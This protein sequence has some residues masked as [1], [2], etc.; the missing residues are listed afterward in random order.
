MRKIDFD[1]SK[2]RYLLERM[3]QIFKDYA[4]SEKDEETVRIY[5]LF[6]HKDGR[7]QTKCLRFTSEEKLGKHAMQLEKKYPND[8]GKQLGL[9]RMSD[10]K[11]D[12]DKESQG[13]ELLWEAIN[14]DD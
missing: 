10:Y 14:E 8:V 13:I 7:T 12:D 2:K 3:T 5:M 6:K 9:I 11:I 1:K 4:L